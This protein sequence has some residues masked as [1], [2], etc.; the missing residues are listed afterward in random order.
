MG[1]LMLGCIAL[2]LA[3]IRL[4]AC[5]VVARPAAAETVSP[6]FQQKMPNITGK[7][8]TVVTVEFTPGTHAAPHRHGQA[9]LYAYVLDGAVRSQLEGQPART[10]AV[11][12]GWSEPP[13]SHH[14]LTESA[15]A[16]E[17]AR[18]LVVFVAD[19]GAP[20]KIDDH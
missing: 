20:L 3:G 9:F 19:T 6:V 14:V 15:R 1:A 2:A 17:P 12:E 13:G 11:G 16:R 8:S 18:L 7:T 4:A 10:Y 5:L